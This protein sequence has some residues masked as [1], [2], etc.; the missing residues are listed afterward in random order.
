MNL[1]EVNSLA[2]DPGSV[3]WPLKAVVITALMGVILFLGY[4]LIITNSIEEL[5][6]L[7]RK[8]LELRTTFETKQK[9]ASQLAAYE[10]QLAEMQHSFGTLMQQLPSGTEIPALILDISEKGVSNGLE[11]ELFE[12]LAEVLKEFYAE[13]PIKL[14]ALG[15][16]QQLATFVSDISGLPRIVTIHNIHLLPEIARG[17]Q[18]YKSN[19]SVEQE[20]SQRLRMEALI[21]TYRYLEDSDLKTASIDKAAASAATPN[22]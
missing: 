20:G 11:I 4:K 21:K 5:D 6:G 16:Y 12:P 7:E 15:T 13:K 14:I 17:T 10:K 22:R 9:R 2:D 1:Q 8:E 18:Q 3:P 19:N